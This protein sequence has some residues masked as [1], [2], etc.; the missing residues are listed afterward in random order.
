MHL[1][2][3]TYMYI[4]V[5]VQGI[6]H[7]Y[8]LIMLRYKCIIRR[9]LKY[10]V[11]IAIRRERNVRRVLKKRIIGL[12][13]VHRILQWRIRMSGGPLNKDIKYAIITYTYYVLVLTIVIRV[14]RIL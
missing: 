9:I 1:A 10:G 3:C 2:S 6:L 5:I 12:K 14:R 13:Y 11:H 7:S 4:H 8:T